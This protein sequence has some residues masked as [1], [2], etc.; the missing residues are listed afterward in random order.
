[1]ANKAPES[2]YT[3]KY[4]ISNHALERFRER[5]EDD[6]RCRSNADI[7]NLLDEKVCQATKTHSVRNR[8]APEAITKLHAI[9]LRSG[10]Y[11]AVVR[12]ATVV[13]VLDENMVKDNYELSF[14]PV[15]N[16]PFAD[17][18][19]DMQR[20]TLKLTPQEQVVMLGGP[21]PKKPTLA[22]KHE[23]SPLEAAGIKHARALKRVRECERAVAQAEEA[24]NRAVV[25]QAAAYDQRD[26]A[27][28]ELT[29]LVQEPA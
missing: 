28:R 1:M 19:R 29:A 16:A 11:Y 14:Q 7:G 17:K 4:S 24:L 5:V 9:E 20:Q 21:L 22:E 15:L 12:D 18:L 23:P 3:R 27:M 2:S 8:R 6:V 10:T 25:E 13:T 26:E